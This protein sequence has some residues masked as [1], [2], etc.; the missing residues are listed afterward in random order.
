M[1]DMR[2]DGAALRNALILGGT[3]VGLA[4]VGVLIVNYV[5]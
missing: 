1:I 3:I 5:V 2:K 4:I